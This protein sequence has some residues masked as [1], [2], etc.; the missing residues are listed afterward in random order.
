MSYPFAI[1]YPTGTSIGA[2]TVSK[3]WM[4]MMTLGQQAFGRVVTLD[5][6]VAPIALYMG[7]VYHTPGL[8]T[9]YVL[10]LDQ[11][12]D[13]SVAVTIGGGSFLCEIQDMEINY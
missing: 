7:Y 10:K 4:Y 3:Y 12:L 1:I 6:F 13:Y 9:T 5:E 8:Q 2:K 11:N